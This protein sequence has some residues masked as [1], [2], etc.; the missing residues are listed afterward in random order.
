MQNKLVYCADLDQL[1]SCW[2]I[3]LTWASCT[4]ASALAFSCKLLWAAPLACGLDITFVWTRVWT[5]ELWLEGTRCKAARR[6]VKENVKPGSKA[7]AG[8][9]RIQCNT[10]SMRTGAVHMS[11]V[12]VLTDYLR[13]CR[14]CR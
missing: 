8:C 4:H 13:I 7:T 10:R 14:F 5:L 6:G 3:V 1:H 12:K 2:C 9:I 11:G